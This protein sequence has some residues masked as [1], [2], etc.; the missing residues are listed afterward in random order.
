MTDYGRGSGSEAWHPEDPLFGDAYDQGQGYQ[1]Q[2][3]HPQQGGWQDPYATGQQPGYPQQDYSQ[4]QYPQQQF[5][6]EQYQQRPA[7]PQQPYGGQAGYEPYDP[8][9][10][11]SYQTGGY[12]HQDPYGGQQP[13]DPY[14]G[15]GQQPDLYGQNGYPPPQQPQFR[16][17]PQQAGPGMG[18]GQP[19]QPMGPGGMG[20]PGQPG[21]GAAPGAQGL[22][23]PG[24]PAGRPTE[25]GTRPMRTAPENTG[26]W[27]DTDG[28]GPREHAFFADRDDDDDEDDDLLP[29]SSGGRRT[30]KSAG[31]DGKKRR[32]GCACLVVATLL[33]G[34]VGGAGYYGYTF[35][36]S[37]FGPAPDYSGQ[38]TG[39]VQVTI[40]SGSSLTAM[41]NLLKDAGVVK[42]VGAFTAAANKNPKGR[43]IQAGVYLLHKQMS[44]SAAVSMML[45]PASQNAMIIPEGLRATAV[46]AAI[47]KKLG[48]AAGTTAKS[49][50][51]VNVGLPSWA[52]GDIEGFLWPAKYSVAKGTKPADLI[53]QMVSR[54]NAEYTKDDLQADAAKLHRTPREIITIA[55]L[56]Q[57]EAQDPE[58][59]G[60]VS[61]VIYNRLDQGTALGFDSTINYAMGRSTLDTSTKDTQYPSPYN[62]YTHKGLPPGPIDNPGHDAIEAAL[63][64]TPGKWLYFVT[65]KPHDT[66]FAVTYAD[67]QKNVAEFNKYQKEH[68]G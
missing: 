14:G 2:Q 5:A 54:A 51:G 36:Q 39:D 48:L 38:G 9:D 24:G 34:A 62:T 35:Y 37:H 4:Q 44:A 19:G 13:Q 22:R 7:Q 68:G 65:V 59:F 20:Q 57:A 43:T 25:P 33:V 64:P 26:E 49:V 6:Q 52:K 1:Q 50:K 42:S 12:A 8:Y 67:H 66:R 32:S 23:Q 41:G 27:E 21:A 3:Q 10:T 40:P 60:K 28:P 11:G 16:G 17:H 18:Q 61:R 30:G 46:Y 45:D 58:D 47:D 63:N 31:R 55:S 15:S 29:S 53:K 56:I